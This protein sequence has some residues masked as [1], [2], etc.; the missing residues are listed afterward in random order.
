MSDEPDDLDHPHLREMDHTFVDRMYA[1]VVR[2]DGLSPTAILEADA[3]RL[4]RTPW[5]AV[6]L[7]NILW[8]F[9]RN[10]KDLALAELIDEIDAEADKVAGIPL[11]NRHA[12][13]E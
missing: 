7:T 1:A 6:R 2:I 8:Y 10:S 11:P 5:D 3:W 4:M 13:I 9:N 12:R